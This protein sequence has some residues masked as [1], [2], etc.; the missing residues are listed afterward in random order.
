MAPLNKVDAPETFAGSIK[1]L[2]APRK[3]S[4]YRRPFDDALLALPLPDCEAEED[5]VGE[6]ELPMMGIRV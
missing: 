4:S 2:D 6:F 5:R 3:I 1:I